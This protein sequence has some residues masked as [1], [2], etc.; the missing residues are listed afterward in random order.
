MCAA[1]PDVPMPTRR[2]GASYL[3][4]QRRQTRRG[5]VHVVDILGRK[6]GA[7]MLTGSFPPYGDMGRF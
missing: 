5:V 3:T 6:A 1:A 2:L 7:E 4:E